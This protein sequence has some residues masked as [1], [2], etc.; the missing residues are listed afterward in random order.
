MTPTLTPFRVQKY[1]AGL[2]NPVRKEQV[3]QRA[4]QLGADR[5]V[6]GGLSCEVGHPDQQPT[7]GCLS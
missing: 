4:K 7:E 3:I 1:L 5:Q 2:R 6:L